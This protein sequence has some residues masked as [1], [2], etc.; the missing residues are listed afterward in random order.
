MARVGLPNY[1]ISTGTPYLQD[2]TWREV[3]NRAQWNHTYHA[4]K[5][6]TKAPSYI[7]FNT[8]TNDFMGKTWHILNHTYSSGA[9]CSSYR[10]NVLKPVG[11]VVQ[12]DRT[13]SLSFEGGTHSG[14]H[15][16]N[17][18]ISEKQPPSFRLRSS[19]SE[20][21]LGERNFYQTRAARYN[22]GGLRSTQ[23]PAAQTFHRVLHV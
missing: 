21:T 14:F 1:K 3:L 7:N 18:P 20:P 19:R 13:N 15:P 11:N 4:L 23:Q 22:V 10:F 5:N 6:Q 17:V 16:G 12:M 9:G 2:E 8:T